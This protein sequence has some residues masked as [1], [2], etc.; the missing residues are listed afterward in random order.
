MTLV[1][2]SGSV[3]FDKLHLAPFRMCHSLASHE[4][5]KLP[6]LVELAQGMPRDR[7]EYNAGSVDVNQKDKATPGV[8]LAVEDVIRQI[9]TCGAWMVIKN[10][11]QKIQSFF[12]PNL[13][14]H[15]WCLATKKSISST[16][17]HI[18]P[19]P[20]HSWAQNTQKYFTNT[21][22]N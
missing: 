17:T 5:F 16:Q 12:A 7:I 2:K 4:L 10:V 6:R 20:F 9:E 3:D 22:T 19:P 15:L 11:E 21:V 1:A 13:S 14:S 8:D 18:T